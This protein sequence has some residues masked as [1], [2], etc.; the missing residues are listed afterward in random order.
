MISFIE[1]LKLSAIQGVFEF[2]PVS[3]SAHLILFSENQNLLIDLCL[4]LGS[5]LAILFFFRKDLINFL[6]NKEFFTKILVATIPVA[7]VG[8]FLHITGIIHNLRSIEVIAWTTLIFGIILYLSDKKEINKTLNN[9]F[10]YKSAIIIGLF[11]I[12]SLVPGVSRSGITITAGRLLGFN[13]ID[14]LKVSFF[15]SIPTLGAAS[16]FGLY[17]LNQEGNPELNILALAAIFLSF[18]F[19]YLTIKLF[20]N[21]IK[22]FS[23]NLFV[24]YRII[25]STILLYIIYL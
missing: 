25:L 15:L 2:L 12:L 11:Q 23:L 10:K 4:H 13:R 22:K 9:E 8:Y 6:N 7:F 17:N 20:F 14:S 16:V 1:I 5:L 3:S 18:F 21:Y 24:I 19:S